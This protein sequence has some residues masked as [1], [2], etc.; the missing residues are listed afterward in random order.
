MWLVDTSVWID[1]LRGSDNA[2]VCKLKELLQLEAN[3]FLTPIIYQEILQGASSEKHLKQYRTYFQS[4]LFVHPSDPTETHYQAARI[5][6]LCRKQGITI[7]S[8]IDCLI[9]RIAIEHDLILLHN[10]R[11]FETM[12]KVITKLKIRY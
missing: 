12:A 1:F 2:P 7:R 9:A 4:Q 3:F 10:D 5:Y 11:D 8:T 6:Y